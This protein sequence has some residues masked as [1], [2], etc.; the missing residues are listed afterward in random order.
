MVRCG[1]GGMFPEIRTLIVL[2]SLAVLTCASAEAVVIEAVAAVVQNQLIFQSQLENPPA[3]FPGIA[4]PRSLRRL[5]EDDEAIEL[6]VRRA[7]VLQE[8]RRLGIEPPQARKIE[9]VLDAWRQEKEAEGG[10]GCLVSEEARLYIEE[11]LLIER[12][13]TAKIRPIVRITTED[14]KR[15]GSFSDDS[16][17]VSAELLSAEQEEAIIEEKIDQWIRR[18]VEE[19]RKRVRVE[20]KV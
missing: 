11:D 3:G 20:K 19:I 2:A 7:L 10:K 5:P 15:S 18:W 12:F 17:T 6:L 16:G 14:I 4:V 8:I 1:F 9:T 13:V